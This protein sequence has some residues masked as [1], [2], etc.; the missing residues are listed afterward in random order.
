MT[1]TQLQ[2]PRCSSQRVRSQRNIA[3][4]II[5]GSA[6]I[7]LGTWSLSRPG[8]QIV[9]VLAIGLGLVAMLVFFSPFRNV[10]RCRSCGFRWDANNPPTPACPKPAAK[11][12][13]QPRQRKKRR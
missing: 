7:V 13:D 12:D 4:G 3:S 10:M 1:Q 5:Y 2:C 8:G 6:M 11:D 9:G